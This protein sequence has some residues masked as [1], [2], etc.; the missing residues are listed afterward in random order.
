[1]SDTDIGIE[2]RLRAL[3]GPDTSIEIGNDGTPKV[4]PP[5]TTA[6]ALVLQTAAAEGWTVRLA[7]H[8]S[9]VPLDAPAQL[10]LSSRALS[11]VEEVRAVDLVA[12]VQSG[13]DHNTL[14][15]ALADHGAWWPVDAPGT[16]RSVG[17]LVATATAGPLRSGF[18]SLRDHV[19]GLTLV[20][21][22]GRIIKCGGTVAKNVAGF[23]LTK[24]ATGS[25]GAFGF[26]TSVHLRLR[27]IPRADVTF[28]TSGERD[29]LIEQAQAVLDAGL[30]PSALELL[31]PVAAG[32]KRWTLAVRLV[33]A[34]PTVNAE[35]NGVKGA[36][37]ASWTDLS[38]RDA[39][40]F[41]QGT[42]RRAASDV[43]TIRA[44]T[45]VTGLHRV[46]DLLIHHLDDEFISASVTAGA[47]RW[48]GSATAE[49][50]KIVRHAAAQIEVPLTLERAPWPL[51]SEVG[52]FGAYREGVSRLMG[53]L[54]TTFDPS[55]TLVVALGDQP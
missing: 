50:V 10:T 38:P 54:R 23:D 36:C 27:T 3:V 31:S 40:E 49:H 2:R 11:Q 21:A 4:A 42:L 35:R 9:W 1:M 30:A 22:D 46:I 48:S 17:S 33:G 14:R 19:L 15:A 24:L 25:F 39:A 53:S 6:C 12:T 45:V 32:V 13:V 34:D 47:V 16:M 43:V 44:G 29:A 7:G 52:H 55:G 8:E 51:R 18:G 37:V 5:S 28:I 26:I 41:W 20:T